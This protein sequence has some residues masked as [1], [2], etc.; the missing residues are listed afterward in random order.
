MSPKA[1]TQYVFSLTS[2][3]IPE[4]VGT[5]AYQLQYLIKNGYKVPE[6]HACTWDAHLSYLQKIED[7]LLNIREELK[8]IINAIVKY[9]VRSSA[10]VED[11]LDHSFA[12]RLR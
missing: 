6:S 2:K 4:A 5:K 7:I 8:H 1:N 11:S 3:Q 9:A 10:N 12:G